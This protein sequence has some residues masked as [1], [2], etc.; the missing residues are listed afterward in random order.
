M[1]ER[2]WE[3]KLATGQVVVWSGI[4]GPDAAQRYVDCHREAAVVA[5]RSYPRYGLF[6]GV[7]PDQI[8]EPGDWRWKRRGQ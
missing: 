3:L 7:D 8:I 5:T 4:S 6:I 2:E 1:I